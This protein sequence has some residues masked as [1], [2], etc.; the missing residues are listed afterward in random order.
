MT[1]VDEH[2][3]V[4]H[5]FAVNYQKDLPGY[6]TTNGVIV[7]PGNVVVQPTLMVRWT[8]RRCR[9]YL[10]A[11]LQSRVSAAATCA[12]YGHPRYCLL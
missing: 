10:L 8:W 7:K 9:A 5:A 3:N 4:V 11:L 1:A 12:F 6:G 2:L